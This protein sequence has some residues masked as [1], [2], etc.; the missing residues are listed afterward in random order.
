MKH[1]LSRTGKKIVYYLL[2]SAIVCYVHRW[3]ND[4]QRHAHVFRSKCP[5]SLRPPW[6]EEQKLLGTCMFHSLHK[7]RLVLRHDRFN[8]VK[9]TNN[10]IMYWNQLYR[11]NHQLPPTTAVSPACRCTADHQH[12]TFRPHHAN[13][14]WHTALAADITAHHLQNCAADIWLLSWPMSEV[15]QRRVYS[16][17]HCD[18]TFASKISRPQWP[19]RPARAVSFWLPQFSCFWTDNLEQSSCRHSKHWHHAWTV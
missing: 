15:L 7:H 9:S 16:C 14:S 8:L 3:R 4:K 12:P 10:P 19:R 6:R 17:A 1:T 2:D 18:C 5:Q 13:T 11:T